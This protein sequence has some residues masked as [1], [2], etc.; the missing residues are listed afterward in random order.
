MRNSAV[1]NHRCRTIVKRRG[2]TGC[3][4]TVLIEGWFEFGQRLDGGICPG[5]LIGIEQQG[6]AFALRDGYGC[7]FRLEAT[8]LDSGRRALLGLRG[9]GVLFLPGQFV[10]GHEVFC[11]DTHMF[12]REGIS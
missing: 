2:V 4:A 3:D 11:G 12:L 7:D 8:A 10:A 1:L 6:I 5:L 9:E